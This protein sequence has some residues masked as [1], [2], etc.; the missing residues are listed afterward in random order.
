V[1]AG[2]IHT[3]NERCAAAGGPNCNNWLRAAAP[4]WCKAE[5]KRHLHRFQVDRSA[6]VTFGKNSPQQDFYFARDLLM[7][8]RAPFFPVL[9]NLPAGARPDAAGRSA[10]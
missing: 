3:F 6:L 8:C 10:R 9:S 2:R 4:P 5:R 7:D 1:L